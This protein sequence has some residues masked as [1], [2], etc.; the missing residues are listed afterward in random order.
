MFP[1]LQLGPLAI[2]VPGLFMLAGV[3]IGIMVT[4][5]TAARFNLSPDLLNSLV[6]YALI[7]GVVG[8]R[9]AYVL[10]YFETYLGNPLSVLALNP[11]TLSPSEGLLAGVLAAWVFGQRKGLKLWRTL[12]ALTPGLAVFMVAVALAHVSSGDA[13]GSPTGV[14]WAIDLWGA[15]RHPSQVYELVGAA[16]ILGLVIR[17]RSHPLPAG[18]YTLTFVSLT[19]AAHLL[20]EGFRGDSALIFGGVRQAQIISLAILLAALIGIRM[21][22]VKSQR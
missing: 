7:A 6:F 2:Q 5:R 16:I 10:R 18:M 20:L 1:I 17:L 11:Y 13:F 4:E 19:S 8:A 14:P 15:A 21:R 3:W 12:D 22:S 9:L